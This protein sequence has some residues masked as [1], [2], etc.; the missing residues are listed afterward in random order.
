MRGLLEEQLGEV[1]INVDIEEDEQSKSTPQIVGL[2]IEVGD[3]L[4]A[5]IGERQISR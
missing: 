3:A 5:A 4:Y 1:N 2:D